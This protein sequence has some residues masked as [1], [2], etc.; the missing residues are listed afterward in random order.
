MV[1]VGPGINS[2][3][4]DLLI[5]AMLFLVFAFIYPLY[6][7]TIYSKIKEWNLYSLFILLLLIANGSLLVFKLELIS[8]LCL[9][10]TLIYMVG[11]LF[12]IMTN[13]NSLRNHILLVELYIL[14]LALNI[15]IYYLL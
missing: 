5:V 13:R 8:S 12:I 10:G 9:I 6:L 4:I 14:F 2:N 7:S 1:M 3:S 15:I 11:H